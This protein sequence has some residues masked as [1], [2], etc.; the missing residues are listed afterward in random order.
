MGEDPQAFDDRYRAFLRK[1]AANDRLASNTKTAAL[2]GLVTGGTT[3]AIAR[4]LAG[5]RKIAEILAGAA[6][7]GALGGALAGGAT[8]LGGKLLGAEDPSDPSHFTKSGALG[9]VVAGGLAGGALG[10]LMGGGKIRMPTKL[11]ARLGV[12]D[13][14]IMDKLA[15]L[16][17]APSMR[18]AK[19]GALIGGGTLGAVGGFQGGD[20]GMQLDFIKNQSARARKRRAAKMGIDLN[21]AEYT[22]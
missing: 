10:G 20:E 4:L 1:E 19:I 5:K 8:Y 14:L 21:Q 9:G 2:S 13:N 16:A 15:G 12:G 3:G 7:T 22:P 11:L 17:A 6:G 18:N